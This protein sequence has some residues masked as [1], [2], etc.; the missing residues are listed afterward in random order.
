[1]KPLIYNNKVL[2][3]NG[4]V[5]SGVNFPGVKQFEV[6]TDGTLTTDLQHYYKFDDWKDFWGT[7][8]LTTNVH[9]YPNTYYEQ[10]GHTSIVSGGI[11]NNRIYFS[12][13]GKTYSGVQQTSNTDFG[14][15]GSIA[16][17]V[18]QKSGAVDTNATYI[19]GEPTNFAYLY[20]GKEPMNIQRGGTTLYGRLTWSGWGNSSKSE[21]FGS[22]GSA[23]TE[24]TL[25]HIIYTW[26]G[27]NRKGYINNVQ[28]W[29]N[30][31]SK[32]QSTAYPGALSFGSPWQG[33][34]G[35]Q[36]LY[37][38]IE[39]MGIWEKELSSQERSDIY[40]SGNGNTMILG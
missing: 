17:W 11:R 18:Y 38:Y 29:S 22:Y 27:T 3:Q 15:S 9:G 25:V 5:W 1:M 39:E 32:G 16:F 31:S 35:R 7:N 4:K 23:I 8:D 12:D 14:S 10:S 2:H 33:Q 36:S 30:T 34:T 19:D 20:S 24:N 40:G 21:A 28:R 26:N 13:S 6:D 37:G